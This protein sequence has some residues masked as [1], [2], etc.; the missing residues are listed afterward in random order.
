M[1]TNPEIQK[2]AMEQLRW[3]PI[4]DAA[5]IGVSVKNGIVTLSGLVHS[6]PKKL[7]AEIAVKKV[8]GVKAVAENIVV[9]IYPD[10]Q[11]TIQNW[12][13]PWQTC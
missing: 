10:Q 2:N 5:E 3:Q 8:S 13:R 6:Y 12:L 9:H 4:L 1:K 11:K 7:A